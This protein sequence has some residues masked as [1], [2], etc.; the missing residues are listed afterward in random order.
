MLH[1]LQALVKDGRFHT[2]LHKLRKTWATRLACSGV[3]VHK[4]QKMLGHKSL[5]A[6][7]RYL[8]D[9]DLSKVELSRAIEDASY[10]PGPRLV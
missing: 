3:P 8:V 4:L 7:P 6:A 5:V 10:R 2:E 1:D 9:V